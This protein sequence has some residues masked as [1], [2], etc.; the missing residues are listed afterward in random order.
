ML[1]WAVFFAFYFSQMLQVQVGTSSPDLALPVQITDT[2]QTL[3]ITL[4]RLYLTNLHH[5]V[6][7]HY[8]SPRIKMLMIVSHN[9]NQQ[10]R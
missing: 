8:V 3:H 7:C 1:S 4:L 9:G 10:M 5:L 6:S 2:Y